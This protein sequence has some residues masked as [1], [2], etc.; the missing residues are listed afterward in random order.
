MKKLAITLAALALLTGAVAHADAIEEK[1]V[2]SGKTKLDPAQGYILVTGESRFQGVFIRVPDAEDWAA[3][4]AD[5]EKAFAK[6]QKD[7]P[8]KLKNWQNDVDI[9]KQTGKRIPPKPKE[10]TPANVSIGPIEPR[11]VVGFGPNYVYQKD[12]EKSV[13]RYLTSVKP[14]TYIWYGP[15]IFVNGAM[16]GYRNCMG[17]VKLDVKAGVITDTGDFLINVARR[18]GLTGFDKLDREP[19]MF[20]PST[21]GAGEIAP[22][23]AVYGVPE[24]LQSLPSVRAEFFAAGKMDNIYSL[25][26]NRLRPIPGILGYHRDDV[27][28]LRTGK[29]IPAQISPFDPTADDDA[30]EEEAEPAPAK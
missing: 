3:Y 16:G 13:Y 19:G 27:I 20:S 11:L 2:V 4:K 18:D 17:T 5:W 15:A 7:Y 22:S 28:D 12:K 24:T 8:G 21:D 30:D 1:N 29:A 9:A 25:M 23:A 26:V 10:P 14:G 6:A